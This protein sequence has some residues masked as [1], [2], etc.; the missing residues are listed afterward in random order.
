MDPKTHNTLKPPSLDQL[1]PEI[2]SQL[3]KIINYKSFDIGDYLS[4][5]THRAAVL[6]P[7][8][9][10]SHSGKLEVQLTL[11]AARLRAH[12]GE[13]A[14]PGGKKDETD[15]DDVETALREA[16]EEISLPASAVLILGTLDPTTSMGR[17]MVQPIVALIPE[18][19]EP[20]F[21]TEEVSACF[22]VELESFLDPTD[23]TFSQM[24]WNTAPWRD[25]RFVR[26][27]YTITGLTSLRLVRLAELVYER[28]LPEGCGCTGKDDLKMVL[29]LV[30][31]GR[32]TWRSEKRP[33]YLAKL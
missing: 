3:E 26:K 4:P 1:P 16:M 30:E 6:I 13:V 12:G 31:T 9:Y 14:F 32:L 20:E 10:N 28:A 25:H 17:Q 29:H 21:N 22:R 5:V 2:R 27:G 7:L 19:F 11:R 8:L 24:T 18:E 23:Y 15:T 33:D